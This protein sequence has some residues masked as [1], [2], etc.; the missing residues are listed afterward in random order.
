M[1]GFSVGLILSRVLSI[2][3]GTLAGR[4]TTNFTAIN[5]L[6]LA[7]SHID[8]WRLEVIYTFPSVQSSSA[9][10]FVINQS[11]RNGS[12]SISPLNGTTTTLFSVSCPHW[13]DEDGI[14]DYALYGTTHSCCPRGM[15][16]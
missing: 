12:C 7:N 16:W 10:N 15:R 8:F 2:I 6:F 13:F 3:H 1:S 9:L 4:H 14:K 5:E 11:P